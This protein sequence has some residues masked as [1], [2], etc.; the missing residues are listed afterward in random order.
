LHRQRSARAGTG[1]EVI[2]FSDPAQSGT[3]VIGVYGPSG[4]SFTLSASAA[5]VN[6]TDDFVVTAP[7]G[8]RVSKSY[9][10]EVHAGQ[11]IV[12]TTTSADEI[13]LC[14]KLDGSA[15]LADF[16][17][18]SLLPGGNERIRYV[19]PRS[20]TLSIAVVGTTTAHFTVATSD[21][22]DMSAVAFRGRDG[23]RFAIECGA[24]AKAAQVW[25]TDIYTDDSGICTAALHAGKRAPHEAKTVF[26]EMRAGQATYEGSYRNGL[27]SSS[28]GWWHASYVFVDDGAGAIPGGGTARPPEPDVRAD[29]LRGQNGERL[30]VSCAAYVIPLSVWGTD[31]YNPDRRDHRDRRWA[32]WLHR[33]DEKRHHLHELRLLGRK[34][35]LRP[36]RTK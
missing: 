12:V 23:E 17:A 29:W 27:T 33:L 20:G 11:E 1:D 28:Y 18:S 16:D 3:L 6:A 19:A 24:E 31:M 10:L 26:I 25:G 15:S 30:I 8:F 35:L 5:H 36:L 34:L 21:P 9:A 32:G 22:D 14:V 2:R 7:D 13:D 4:S